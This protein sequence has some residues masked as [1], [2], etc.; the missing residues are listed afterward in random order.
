MGDFA[1][2]CQTGDLATVRD[3][4]ENKGSSVNQPDTGVGR[5]TPL[6]WAADYNQSA[7]IEYLISRGANVNCTDAFGNTPLLAAVFE[8]HEQAVASLVSKGA[9]VNTASPDGTTPLQAAEKESIKRIL[10]AGK[11]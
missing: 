9:S 11:K 1:W 5:R 4:V 10:R 6:H 8:G 2:A 7:V 3:F